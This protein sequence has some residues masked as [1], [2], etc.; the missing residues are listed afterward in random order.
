MATLPGLRPRRPSGCSSPSSPCCLHADPRAH[1][2][3]G[4]QRGARRAARNLGIPTRRVPLYV[5]LSHAATWAP[6]GNRPR[7]S[8]RRRRSSRRWAAAATSLALREL[9]LGLPRRLPPAS[10]AAGG[11]MPPSAAATA[12]WRG[13]GV[14]IA[15]GLLLPSPRTPGPTPPWPRSTP[16]HVPP[17]HDPWPSPC[18]GGEGELRA[19]CWA[20]GP[21]LRPRPR[22]P[23]VTVACPARP[24]V[25]VLAA[26]APR[27]QLVESALACL[28]VA[29]L[30]CH[31]SGPRGPGT[32]AELGRPTNLP[33]LFWHVT[34]RQYQAFVSF[35]VGGTAREVWASLT[36]LI[37]DSGCRPRGDPRGLGLRG[38]GAPGPG[39][40]RGPSRRCWPQHW[41]S[42]ALYTIAEDKDAYQL[43]ALLAVVLAAG[44]GLA[45]LVT[46]LRAASPAARHAATLLTALSAAPPPRQ[47]RARAAARSTSPPITPKRVASRSPKTASSHLRLEVYSPLLY[48]QE[49]EARARDVVAVDVSLLRRSGTCR[50]CK[51]AIHGS[52]A[53]S[54]SR[55][56]SSRR[57]SQRGAGPIPYDRR[58]H[59]NQRINARFQG[60][61][62]ALVARS[63]RTGGRSPPTRSWCPRAARTRPSRRSCSGAG[64]CA[65]A[66]ILF[67]LSRRQGF[68]PW[69]PSS[70]RPGA[71]PGEVSNRRGRGHQG[72]AG[73]PHDA[74]E[75]RP[76]PGRRED[77]QWTRQAFERA[78]ALDPDLP[79]GPGRASPPFPR[80]S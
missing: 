40:L 26:R 25:L 60:M 14:L 3:A 52:W 67:E 4:R 68:T 20:A 64:P 62:S 48:V 5:L 29:F 56:R 33:R 53:G 24:R 28:A 75:P 63:S 41:P 70:S 12:L 55:C 58:P 17:G 32:R 15:S 38:P 49:A 44:T 19:P 16:Q 9:L 6:F 54:A 61:V 7:G 78:L 45:D 35:S 36:R 34:G 11:A 76:L 59:L 23:H 77:P 66:G 8:P 57:I 72:A 79:H 31:A 43:P 37:G 27:R 13:P 42:P 74:R 10:D 65:R 22:V 1:G 73:L 50:S 30:L 51:G 2:H 80:P 39:G 21:Y 18:G 69:S 47:R 71:W 46:R